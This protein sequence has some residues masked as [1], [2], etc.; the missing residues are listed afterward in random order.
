MNAVRTLMFALLLVALTITLLLAG[1]TGVGMLL[2]RLLPDVGLG[3]GI[4]IGVLAL[5]VSVNFVLNLLGQANSLRDELDEAEMEE[6]VTVLHRPTRKR[7]P[8]R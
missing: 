1:A 4:L 2:D 3:T 5:S 8:R 7:R 6:L